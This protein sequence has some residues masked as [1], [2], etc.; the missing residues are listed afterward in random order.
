MKAKSYWNIKKAVTKLDH[1]FCT[2]K[3]LKSKF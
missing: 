2:I 1:S 3:G